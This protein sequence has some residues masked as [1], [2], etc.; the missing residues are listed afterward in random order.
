MT[1]IDPIQKAKEK[2][3]HV[4]VFDHHLA[5]ETLPSADVIVDPHIE[6]KSDFSQYCG[7]GIAFRFAKEIL[8]KESPILDKSARSGRNSNCSRYGS[9]VW[10]KPLS[11]TAEFTA[12]QFWDWYGRAS[13]FA[14]HVKL[15]KYHGRNLWVSF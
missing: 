1:A 13:G 9:F 12:D 6:T 8:P 10:S 14:S 4:V 7:A 2:G 3:M 5:G 11:C 15:W